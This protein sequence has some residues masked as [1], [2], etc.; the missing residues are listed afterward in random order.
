M[1]NNNI[2]ETEID[3]SKQIT[4]LVEHTYDNSNLDI[5]NLEQSKDGITYIIEKDNTKTITFES[6]VDIKKYL[7][8]QQ[9]KWLD[10]NAI[11]SQLFASTLMPMAPDLGFYIKVDNI[12]IYESIFKEEFNIIKT[13]YFSVI[14][15]LKEHYKQINSN[16]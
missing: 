13:Q 1:E 5:N 6:F 9:I 16:T 15:K 14:N 10:N 2:Q 3:F 12:E 4:E 7:S 11:K 8:E